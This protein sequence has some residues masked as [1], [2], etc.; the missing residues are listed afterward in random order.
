MPADRQHIEDVYKNLLTAVPD[1]GR[2]T[3]QSQGCRPEVVDF[4]SSL[5]SAICA[6]DIVP[7]LYVTRSESGGVSIEWQ[8]GAGA[9]LSVHSSLRRAVLTTSRTDSRRKTVRRF[10]SSHKEE[11]LEKLTIAVSESILSVP[12]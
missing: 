4:V 11:L 2:R 12:D 7:P 8:H 6:A 5:L 1:L 10:R 3:R 9:F